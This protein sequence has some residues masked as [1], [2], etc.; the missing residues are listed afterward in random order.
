MKILVK[1]LYDSLSEDLVVILLKSFKRSLRD[2]VEGPCQK[3]L[4]R[5][6]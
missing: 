4:R 5:S 3:I 6:C 1:V 2:L